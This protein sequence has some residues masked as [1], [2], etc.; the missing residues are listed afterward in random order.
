MNSSAEK[1]LSRLSMGLAWRTGA[2]AASGA[3]P[4]R[5]LG[6]SGGY[7][8]GVLGLQFE[9]LPEQLSIVRRPR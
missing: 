7:Q 3:P 8:F 4:T 6:E 1:R 9:Q 5:W 2:K